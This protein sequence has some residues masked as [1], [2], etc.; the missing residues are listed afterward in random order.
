MAIVLAESGA[1]VSTDVLCSD[2]GS[3]TNADK[4]TKTLC[5]RNARLNF[6]E[7]EEN[8][9]YNEL[10]FR[11]CSVDVGV[12]EIVGR[13]KKQY[14]IDFVVN[15]GAKK[16]YIQPALDASDPLQNASR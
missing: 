10:L 7:Q 11:G 3:L 8:I 5:L 1:C 15:K 14:E 13:E 16:H 9:I 4:I 2:I 6:R 12:V